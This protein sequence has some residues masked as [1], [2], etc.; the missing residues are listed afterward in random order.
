MSTLSKKDSFFSTT[1]PELD[2]LFSKDILGY[3]KKELS[4]LESTLPSA[5]ID[6]SEKEYTIELAVPGLKKEEL[7]VELRQNVL[8]ISSEHEEEKEEKDE[9]R[10][11]LRKEFSYRSF[12]RS[13]QLPESADNSKVEAIYDN[14]ILRIE[15]GKKRIETNK[16]I[17]TIEVH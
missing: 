5:N 16:Q 8:T 17:K 7:N 4:K 12:K 6:E 10:N 13:F 11:F 9:K 3:T 15:V 1:S 2:E 14:G